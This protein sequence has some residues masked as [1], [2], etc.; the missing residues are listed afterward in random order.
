MFL[1]WYMLKGIS[2]F[3]I[4]YYHLDTQLRIWLSEQYRESIF[5]LWFLLRLSPVFGVYNFIMMCSGAH[6]FSEVHLYRIGCQ[7][8]KCDEVWQFYASFYNCLPLPTPPPPSNTHTITVENISIAPG[9][10]LL[11]QST[12]SY[13][14]AN[15]ARPCLALEI[16][17][18]Q[19][20]ARWYGCRLRGT[21][22]FLIP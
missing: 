10:F 2:I 9:S 12:F 5:F 22:W 7:D 19:A 8:N 13:P 6:L 17:W 16:R 1:F 15:Q 14:S 11:L 21:L 20:H 18:D 3:L 4:L